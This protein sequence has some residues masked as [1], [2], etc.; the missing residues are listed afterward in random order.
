MFVCGGDMAGC[1][2]GAHRSLGSRHRHR[3]GSPITPPPIPPSPHPHILLL[4]TASRHTH[5]SGRR[6]GLQEAVGTA[7]HPTD[8]RAVQRG[9]PAAGGGQ[10]QQ[11]QQPHGGLAT[12]DRA[13]RAAGGGDAQHQ[14]RQVGAGG[15]GRRVGAGGGGD[16][17]R[18]VGAGGRGSAGRVAGL[19][20][21]HGIAPPHSSRVAMRRHRLTTPRAHTNTHAHMHHASN[22]FPS[23]HP[24]G[25]W[26]R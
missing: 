7:R 10:V 4:A 16:A 26:R 17:G 5:H 9:D 18:R 12:A 3:P 1:E 20:S 25:T 24:P 22:R 15:A 23:S 19:P 13:A 6:Q 21:P 11:D 8:A 14:V 2:S